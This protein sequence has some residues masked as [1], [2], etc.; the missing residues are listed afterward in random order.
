MI[1]FTASESKEQYWCTRWNLPEGSTWFAR[2][3]EHPQL[4]AVPSKSRCETPRPETQSFTPF[5]TIVAG[6]QTGLF[7]KLPLLFRKL[8]ILFRFVCF[9]SLFRF[10]NYRKPPHAQGFPL[11]I[12]KRC[13]CCNHTSRAKLSHWQLKNTAR[14]RQPSDSVIYHFC[15]PRSNWPHSF[16]ALGHL[17]TCILPQGR[18]LN[19]T[20][21]ACS[22]YLISLSVKTIS[23][24]ACLLVFFAAFRA[25]WTL[26]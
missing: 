16:S 25:Y 3:F 21:G 9:V 18:F 17:E 13:R 22:R 23:C 4:P 1:G 14:V 12:A 2:D 19:K 26:F 11:T 6:R 5:S 7:R 8:P 24:C 15:C 20:H 10:A